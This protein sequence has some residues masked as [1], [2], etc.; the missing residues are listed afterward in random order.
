[1][2]LGDAKL[3]IAV[4]TAPDCAISASRPGSARPAPIVALSPMLVRMTPKACGPSSRMRR[5][6]AVARMSRCQRRASPS[7]SGGADRITAALTPQRAASSSTPVTA[8]Q[9]TAISASST[10]LPMAAS[11]AKQRRPSSRR[12]FGLTAYRSPLKPPS[13]RFSNT[14]RPSEAGLSDAPTNATDA[15]ASNGRR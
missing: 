12:W 5:F 15:G 9:G 8:A 4:H 14:M 1:M 7:S 2:P 6:F 13:S 11:E 3:S 10:G